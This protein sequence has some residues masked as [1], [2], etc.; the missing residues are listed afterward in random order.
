MNLKGL[1]KFIVKELKSKLSN[2]LTYHGLDHTDRVLDICQRYAELMQISGRNS[3]LL[4][5]A[6]LMHDTGFLFTY[7]D[8]EAASIDYSK[9]ILP[10]W[11]Y[12]RS[13]IE[14]ITKII[15]A[16]KIPQK[17][18]TLLEQIIGDADLDYLGTEQFYPIGEKLYHELMAFNKIETEEEW[19][20]LQVDFLKNHQFHTP[21]AKQYREPVKLKYM[22][23]IMEKWG[24]E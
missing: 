16:T 14:K 17:P 5:T 11:N 8:H 12:N 21:F 20:R 24:W 2:K 7:D 13:E 23:E 19:D 6:A 4:D 18:N 1:Q 22:Y 15:M 3:I 9:E 10:K